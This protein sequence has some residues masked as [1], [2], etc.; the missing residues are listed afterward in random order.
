MSVKGFWVNKEDP[1]DWFEGWDDDNWEGYEFYT[2]ADFFEC[3]E[4]RYFCSVA[5]GYFR[6]KTCYN[7][8][9]SLHCPLLEDDC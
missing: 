2:Y 9:C 8:P 3:I 1:N 6:D 4:G 7:N 5:G